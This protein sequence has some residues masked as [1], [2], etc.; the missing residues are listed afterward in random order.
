MFGGCQEIMGEQ[1]IRIFIKKREKRLN[2]KFRDASFEGETDR[3][4]VN[5]PTG[6]VTAALSMSNLLRTFFLV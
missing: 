5:Q 4:W 6:T 3:H 2:E 1:V